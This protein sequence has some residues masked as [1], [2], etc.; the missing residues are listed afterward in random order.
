MPRYRRNI[1]V[2]VQHQSINQPISVVFEK[3]PIL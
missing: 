2:G 1:K 3:M